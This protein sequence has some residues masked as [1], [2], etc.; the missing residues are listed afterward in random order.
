[1][2]NDEVFVQWQVS[3]GRVDGPCILFSPHEIIHRV[4]LSMAALEI[5][6]CMITKAL[7]KPSL[8]I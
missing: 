3:V 1:M 4:K 2:S 8:A 5:A 7:R 6:S